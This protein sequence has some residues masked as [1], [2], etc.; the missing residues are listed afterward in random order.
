MKTPLQALESAPDLQHVPQEQLQWLI[1]RSE[2]REFAKGDYA[3]RKGDPIDYFYIILEGSIQLRIEQNGQFREMATLTQGSLNGSLPFSRARVAGGFGLC[4]ENATLLMLHR[5]HF[6][7]M[8]AECYE[9]TEALVHFMTSRTRAFT[10]LE[11]QTEKMAAL[12]RISAGL[13]HELNNPSAAIVRSADA[14]KR[15]LSSTPEKFKNVMSLKL[16]AE[17]IDACNDLFFRKAAVGVS[18]TLSPLEKADKEDE[19]LDWLEQRGVEDGYDM[20]ANLTDFAFSVEDLEKVKQIAGREALPTVLGWLD[21]LLTTERF[22]GEIGEASKRINDIV[23][24]VKS[25]SHLDRSNE[26]QA[27][28]I[29]EGIRKTLMIMQHKIKKNGVSIVETFA[30]DMPE[31]KVFVGELNQV[32]TNII[33]NA[34][35]AMENSARKVLEIQTSHKP[36]FVEIRVIDSGE[37]IPPEALNGIFDPF[38]T[39]KQIGKGTGLGLHTV[40]QIIE[41]HNGKITARST[42]GATEFCVCLPVE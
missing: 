4:L 15:H 20:T 16:T 5:D 8:T 26:R 9:L 1:D 10:A 12:G 14:F 23:L 40:R 35:D 31:P 41:R 13:A 19:L 18:Y 30:A 25:Y 38:F 36:G 3:F 42:A 6:R 11:Q 2:R 29:H 24:A 37:G 32:W 17:Q 28:D 34:L 21:N 27:A 39:T 22:V 33:D 7:A